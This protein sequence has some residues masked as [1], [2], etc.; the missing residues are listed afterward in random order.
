MTNRSRPIWIAVSVVALVWLLAWAGLS[1]A[2]HLKVTPDKV[3]H[4]LS[5]LDFAR[6]SPHQRQVALRKLAAMLNALSP[7]ERRAVRLNREFASLFRS[8][9]DA[10]KGE[11]LELTMPSGFNQMLTA[12][13]QMPEDQ[14]R[15]AIEDTMRRLQEQTPIAD[16]L[17]SP[18]N[19]MAGGQ[20][21]SPELRDKMVKLG[22]KTFM[23][24]GT[25]ETKA[26]LQPVL[27]EMQRT[28]EAGRLF[29]PQRRARNE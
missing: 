25:P 9:T 24:Q 27:E 17:D 23:D 5:T 1:V 4:Y 28:M 6:L 7:D 13:E 8:L 20:E 12:F 29:R 14:R 18:G 10:E 19:A 16:G 21:L 3:Q 2:R 15:K 11:F 26:E 22:V